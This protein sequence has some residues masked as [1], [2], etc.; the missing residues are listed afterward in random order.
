[1]VIIKEDFDNKKF[2]GSNYNS[3]DNTSDYNVFEVSWVSK[4]DK[5][6]G[7]IGNCYDDAKIISSYL[8]ICYNRFIGEEN[9]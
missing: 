9:N 6:N 2:Y 1:M 8:A 7:I 4:E 3:N 5:D